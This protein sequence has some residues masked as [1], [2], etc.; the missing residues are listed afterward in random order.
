MIDSDPSDKKV[1]TQWMLTVFNRLLNDYSTHSDAVRF[2][3]EDLPLAS[4]YLLI[5]EQNKRK[6]L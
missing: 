4:E 1:Y 2:V 3:E 6:K 5:F